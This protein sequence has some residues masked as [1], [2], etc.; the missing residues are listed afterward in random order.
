[1]AG[2]LLGLAG[3]SLALARRSPA[4]LLASAGPAAVVVLARSPLFPEG[5]FEPYPI[6]SFARHR[7]GGRSRSSGRCRGVR[8]RCGSGPS[9]YLLACVGCLLV[10]TPV[11]SNIER[12]GVL[13][14]GPLL[15]CARMHAPGR[16]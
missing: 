3:L 7:A 16:A 12:Y 6:L 1:M 4:A 9:V 8:A 11:G 14:A 15:L 13:L 10:H 2:A 5:G